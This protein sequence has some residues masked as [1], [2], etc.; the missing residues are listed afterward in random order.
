MYAASSKHVLS[1]E[2]PLSHHKDDKR[3]LSDSLTWDGADPVD[4]LEV[5]A[6]RNELVNVMDELDDKEKMVAR[7][8]FGLDD[9]IC[10]TSVMS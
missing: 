5:E 4:N 8:R 10:K 1:L 7:M 9:G 6:L 2:L 3:T